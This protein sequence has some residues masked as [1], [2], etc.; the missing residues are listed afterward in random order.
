MRL[1]T[2]SMKRRLRKITL[3]VCRLT[4]TNSSADEKGKENRLALDEA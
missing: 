2:A 3:S 4:Y 1:T